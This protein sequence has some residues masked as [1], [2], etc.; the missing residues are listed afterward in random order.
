MAPVASLPINCK[1]ADASSKMGTM[2]TRTNHVF[3]EIRDKMSEY[4]IVPAISILTSVINSETKTEMFAHFWALIELFNNKPA[5]KQFEAITNCSKDIVAFANMFLNFVQPTKEKSRKQKEAPGVLF[6]HLAAMDSKQEAVFEEYVKQAFGVPCIEFNPKLDITKGFDGVI[7]QLQEEK[8][9]MSSVFVTI[10]E[11]YHDLLRPLLGAL[12]FISCICGCSQIFEFKWL[13][14]IIKEMQKCA[15]GIIAQRTVMGEVSDVIDSTLEALYSFTG[16]TYIRKKHR[17][18]LNLN[19]EIQAFHKEVKQLQF[20]Y[21]NDQFGKLRTLEIQGLLEKYESLT[22]RFASIT[23]EEKSLFNNKEVM[24]DIWEVL[25][26]IRETAIALTKCG[27]GKQV[28]VRVWL[29]GPSGM[30]KTEAMLELTTE[31]ARV[32]KTFVYGR[33]IQD[34]FFSNYVGQGICVYDDIGQDPLKKGYAEWFRFSSANA[35][36]VIGAAIQAKGTPFTSRYMFASCNYTWIKDPVSV[37]M[38][39]A[40]GRRRDFLVYV[41]NPAV[42][43]YKLKNKGANPPPE[44]WPQ[45]PSEFWLLDPIYPWHKGNCFANPDDIAAKGFQHE[46]VIGQ[47]TLEEL[48]MLI[49]EKEK[50]NAEMYRRK[51]IAFQGKLPFEIPKPIEYDTNYTDLNNYMIFRDTKKEWAIH[52]VAHYQEMT[53][54]SDPGSSSVHLGGSVDDDTSSVASDELMAA[55]VYQPP[56]PCKGIVSHKIVERQQSGAF[57]LPKIQ[58]FTHKGQ[59]I[60]Y[61]T[62]SS[63]ALFDAFEDSEFAQ[64]LVDKIERH[65]DWIVSNYV[66]IEAIASYCEI[67]GY[68][69]PIISVE[70]ATMY[71]SIGGK[72][73]D[74]ISDVYSVRYDGIKANSADQVPKI[75]SKA[76]L[77][78][79]AIFWERNHYTL[80]ERDECN[81]EKCSM[82]KQAVLPT[83]IQYATTK[84]ALLI[85]GDP[86]VGKTACLMA[87]FGTQLVKIEGYEDLQ[88]GKICWLDDI[89]SSNHRMSEA[90]RIIEAFNADRLDIGGLVMT[91][92]AKTAEWRNYPDT[93]IMIARRCTVITVTYSLSFRMSN[94]TSTL[95]CA[96]AIKDMTTQER[97]KCLN[98]KT[99]SPDKKHRKLKEFLDIENFLST[100]FQNESEQNVPLIMEDTFECPMPEEFDYLIQVNAAWADI[101]QVDMEFVRKNVHPLKRTVENG[102]QALEKVG[103]ME[104]LAFLPK[105]G[106]ILAMDVRGNVDQFIRAVNAKKLDS[107]VPTTVVC[108]LDFT[109]GFITV[110]NRMIAFKVTEFETD[111]VISP[112]GVTY[113]GREYL[114][115]FPYD[116]DYMEA[117]IKLSHHNRFRKEMPNIPSVEQLELS[118]WEESPFKVIGSLL[119]NMATLSLSV[120]SIWAMIS[121]T[122]KRR[123]A[124]KTKVSKSEDSS[125]S[126]VTD[127]EMEKEGRRGQRGGAAAKRNRTDAFKKNGDKDQGNTKHDTDP[128]DERPQ[129]T[130]GA[131]QRNWAHE[132]KRGIRGGQQ[133]QRKVAQTKVNANNAQGNT[134]HDTDPG[135]ERVAPQRGDLID[136]KWQHE[137]YAADILSKDGAIVC[138]NRLSTV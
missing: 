133:Q 12:V 57:A 110:N 6:S 98:V 63:H 32:D 123:K 102:Q 85:L 104:Y 99:E 71:S 28:P 36:T 10:F 106:G 82:Q 62:C 38:A 96:N 117:L 26:D 77:P 3:Q 21:K 37:T 128:G 4:K 87:S 105:I 125:S 118:L 27:A 16:N 116:Q 13:A 43:E 65:P 22:N 75:L 107:K 18:L 83:R 124:K 93:T 100:F 44:W 54:E 19:K 111:L 72:D 120:G 90:K 86:G 131:I 94:M 39:S 1:E 74:V 138:T 114:A 61:F 95:R 42:A 17:H 49:I 103:P 53:S 25:S 66:D 33:T 46:A 64:Y 78:P 136:R 119:F 29:S 69:I 121:S 48:L 15:S 41:H 101:S 68:N 126:S 127:D 50:E 76:Q 137:S 30:G 40:L 59:E 35:E 135:D 73:T 132:G 56:V 92:N 24:S 88:P 52:K 7:K 45:H 55:I 47:I 60:S 79:R 112:V 51:L 134:K 91:G 34:E 130:R 58:R 109:L 80:R 84:R 81:C 97:S 122:A 9:P 8:A 20:E 5:K 11:K 89:T 23:N 2:V 113:E 67:K 31:L 108:G 14:K 70:P 115:N 129:P